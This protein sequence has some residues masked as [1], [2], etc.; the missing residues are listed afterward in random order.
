MNTASVV[1]YNDLNNRCKL[2]PF[3]MNSISFLRMVKSVFNNITGCLN[4]EQQ[5]IP[6]GDAKFA[7]RPFTL[8]ATNL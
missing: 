1:F 4:Q 8:N 3:N 6:Q 5:A 7:A 2:F